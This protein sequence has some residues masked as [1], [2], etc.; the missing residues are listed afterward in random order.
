MTH[1]LRFLKA[2]RYFA[3]RGNHQIYF[4]PT[5]SSDKFAISLLPNPARGESIIG[6]TLAS[7]LQEGYKSFQENYRFRNVLN[8]FLMENL[9]IS[10]N[11]KSRA[12]VFKGEWMHVVD[13]RAPPIFER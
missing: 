3:I 8:E 7:N 10:E 4:N 2:Y 13:E 11:Y 9:K 5:Q 12:K 1:L 6:W